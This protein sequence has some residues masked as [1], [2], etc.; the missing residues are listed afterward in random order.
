MN[1]VRL[2]ERVMKPN[3]QTIYDYKIIIVWRTLIPFRQAI[4]NLMGRS[5]D[6]L[7]LTGDA[8]NQ[9]DMLREALQEQ[10]I[11]VS[12]VINALRMEL[13]YTFYKYKYAGKLLEDELQVA[14]EVAFPAF[15]EIFRQRMFEGL[16]CFALARDGGPRSKTWIKRGSVAMKVMKKLVRGGNVNCVHMYQLLS[17]ELASVRGKTKAATTYYDKA[18]STA[19]RSGFVQDRAL[20]H[21]R[22][23]IFYL[24]EGDKDWASYHLKKAVL[25][26]EN[27]GAAAKIEHLAQTYSGL[28]FNN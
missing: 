14:P 24:G 22:C 23:A 28:D 9:E 18:I 7:V 10:N 13:A 16:T 1:L 17:A 20:A 12:T 2:E 11:L 5:E 6:P 21:E 3:C 8:M 27:W 25:S 19:S 4:L 15:Y 26:Y